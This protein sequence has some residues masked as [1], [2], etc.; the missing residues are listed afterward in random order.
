VTRDG[1]ELLEAL[2]TFVRGY[3]VMSEPQAVAVA[4]WIVH[5]HALDGCEVSPILGVTSAEK[6]SGKTRLLDVL[7][8]LVARPW[9]VV[10][11]SEAVLFRKLDADR[12]TLLLDEVDAIFHV[13]ANGNVEGLR[14]LLN[15]GNRPGTEVPRCV[16]PSQSLRSFKVFS[17]KAL[18]GI[19]ELP[20]T[21]ADRAILIRLKRRS[22]TEPVER[23]RQ[24]DADEAALPLQ[25]WASSWAGHH[26]PALAEA[27]PELPD[28]LDDRAQDA[29]EPLL[30]IAELAG[31]EWPARARAAALALADAREDD[32]AGVRL[33][34]D[35]RAIFAA[36]DVDRV[37]SATLAAQ[38]HEIEEAPWSEWYGKPLTKTG[39]ARLLAHFDVRPR[40]VRLDDETTAKGYRRDQ[41]DDVFNRYLPSEPETNRH[42]VTT[43]MGSG[44]AADFQPSRVTDE[45][46]RKPAWINGCDGVTDEEPFPGDLGFLEAVAAAHRDGL[47]TTAEALERERL[48]KLIRLAWGHSPEDE[49]G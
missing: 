17:A 11:P 33:L 44:I 30:A 27:R 15:A 3:V 31:E 34:A 22:R 36:Q 19:R 47:L 21:I 35:I 37:S 12:P 26:G 38:L 18:A 5:T 40:T 24:R 16:G 46:T 4:L 45:K 32:S 13:K 10:M 7:E 43:R 14:A 49:L 39:I 25:Q 6:R 29:W 1:R 8:L 42:T 41:F 9:R 28:E 20:D 48:H 23:F 2:T